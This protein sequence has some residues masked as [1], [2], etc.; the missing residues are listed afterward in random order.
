VSGCEPPSRAPQLAARRA[1]M[2]GG[3]P[4]EQPQ[5]TP[6]VGPDPPWGVGGTLDRGRAPVGGSKPACGRL[7]RKG[8]RPRQ[9]A[10]T[11]AASFA[12]RSSAP[13]ATGGGRRSRRWCPANSR[14]RARPA[15][16]E[17]LKHAA[18]AEAHADAFAERSRGVGG[19]CRPAGR[20]GVGTGLALP[21][22]PPNRSACFPGASPAARAK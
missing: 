11:W 15:D 5:S 9:E 12:Q 19:G 22:G 7:D 16:P 21:R 20:A 6:K 3:R 18:L 17:V 2:V 14:R 8:R 13:D 1:Y 4:I 10:A